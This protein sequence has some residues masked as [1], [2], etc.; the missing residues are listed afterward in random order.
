MEWATYFLSGGFL[1]G[2]RTM[3][4]AGALVV[5]LVVGYLVG[6]MG[7]MQFLGQNWMGIA[8]ALGLLTAAAHATPTA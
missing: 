6:D 1:K 8:T 4:L 2:Y 3:L 5:N 7:L